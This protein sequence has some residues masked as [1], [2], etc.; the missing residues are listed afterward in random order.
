MSIWNL[1]VI[2]ELSC[3][4]ISGSESSDVNF[5]AYSNFLDLVLTLNFF[6]LIPD[7]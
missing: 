7:R 5:N 1:V 3:Q 2:F 4:D 6:P